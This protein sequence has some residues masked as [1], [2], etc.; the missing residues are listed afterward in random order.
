MR[1]LLLA[2]SV[3]LSCLASTVGAA[4][5]P[6]TELKVI[7]STSN[8]SVWTDLEK[9]WYEKTIPAASKGAVKIEA[10]PNDLAGLKGPEVLSLLQN[11]TIQFASQAISY[12]AGDDP[13]FEAVDLAA[14]TL[15]VPTARKAIDAYRPVLE[16]AL[17]E[18][19]NIKLLGM[20]PLTAQVFWCR[21][22]VHGVAD[23]KGKKIRVFNATL[24]DMVKGVGGSSVTIPFVEAVPALQ[25]GVA[26]CG[27]TGVVSGYRAK[28]YE[29]TKTL[30][31]LNAGWSTIF[32]AANMDAWKALPPQTQAFLAD[33]YKQMETRLG[34]LA[35]QND[36]EAM[37]CATGTHCK[38]ADAGRMVFQPISEQD[39]AERLRLLQNDVLPA[40]AKRCGK[41]C[42]DE[43]NNTVGKALGLKAEAK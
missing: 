28:W 40:W 43:W 39:Q 29:V 8:L 19:F 21:E 12:M 15:D 31:P 14:L 25:R 4:D 22:P 36:G 33:Q 24:A 16:K 35:I 13:R 17:A 9:D 37:N 27:V 3:A 2:T 11:G 5:L 34:D 42:A 7:G 20:A 10:L 32:W 30:Y 41:A 6:K 38:T 23:L 1:N 26:D 18:R